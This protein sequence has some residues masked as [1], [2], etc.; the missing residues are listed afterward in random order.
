ME[1]DVCI[2]GDEVATK[3]ATDWT[4]RGTEQEGWL[5]RE[6]WPEREGWSEWEGG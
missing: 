3:V 4:A 2:D 1:V 5:G 6:G